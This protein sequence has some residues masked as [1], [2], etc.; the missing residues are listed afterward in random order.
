MKDKNIQEPS[1][2]IDMSIESHRV[3]TGGR[4][5]SYPVVYL[6][7]ILKYDHSTD[8]WE[9]AG[10]MMEGRADLAVSYIPNLSVSC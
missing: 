9:A 1:L 6:D 4:N 2:D 7:E 3:N 5:S 10:T 8:Q